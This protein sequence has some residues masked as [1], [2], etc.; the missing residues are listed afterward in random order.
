MSVKQ[1]RVVL[2]G[3]ILGGACAHREAPPGPVV[4]GPVASASAEVV[5]ASSGEAPVDR[6]ALIGPIPTGSASAAGADPSAPED[7]LPEGFVHVAEKGQTRCGNLLIERPV[8][9]DGEAGQRFVRALSSDGQRVYEAHGQRY[10]L[11]ASEPG[12]GKWRQWMTVE[13][14]GDLTGDGVPELVLT[15]ATMGAHCCYT[16]HVVSLTKPSKRLMTWEKGD[17]GTPL[18]PVRY[19]PGPWQI[20]GYAVLWPPFNVDEG[21]P[22]LPY[23]GAP[24]VPVV[25]SLRAGEYQLTSMTFKEAFRKQRASIHET[26]GPSED[27]DGVFIAW[28][29]SLAIG[30]WVTEREKPMYKD[31]RK[32]LDRR[33]P[34]MQQRMVRY[35]GSE[36]SPAKLTPLR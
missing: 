12:L 23:A 2:V 17:M 8:E 18:T 32:V 28:A 36:A 13:F 1:W 16:H 10:K 19:R 20:E 21:D 34:A 5:P 9:T 25:F 31:L 15:E 22:S 26:C 33:A 29:D 24:V 27:C 11:E 30:D 7:P 6:A 14:C 35:L 3:A 4:A